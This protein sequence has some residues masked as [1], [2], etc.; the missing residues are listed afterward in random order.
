MMNGTNA[1][2]VQALADRMFANGGKAER[3]AAIAGLRAAGFDGAAAML[4]RGEHV[5]ALRV[6]EAPNG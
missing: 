4:E 2:C 5:E 1:Q 6:A 3:L